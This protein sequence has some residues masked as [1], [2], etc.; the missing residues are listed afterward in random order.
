MSDL[1]KKTILAVV[2]AMALT[3][4]KA[5]EITQDLIK[6]GEV[7]KSDEAKFAREL[8][9]LAE[10][11]MAGMEEKIEKVVAKVLEKLDIPSRKELNDLKEEIKK[12]NKKSGK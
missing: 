6:R 9:D 4:E 2:G 10:K 7:A 3:R 11:N 5:E 12:L 8:M 1:I